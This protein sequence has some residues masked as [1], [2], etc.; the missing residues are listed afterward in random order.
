MRRFVISHNVIYSSCSL[1]ELHTVSCYTHFGRHFGVGLA[2]SVITHA[3]SLRMLAAVS[4]SL[5]FRRFICHLSASSVCR[6]FARFSVFSPSASAYLLA[7]GIFMLPDSVWVFWQTVCGH[8]RCV[9]R[10]LLEFCCPVSLNVSIV[11]RHLL[12]LTGKYHLFGLRLFAYLC[13][14]WI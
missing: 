1:I 12:V 13:L 5:P 10:Q 8:F 14:L 2:V 6:V 3:I 9:L 7:L 4:F 11:F